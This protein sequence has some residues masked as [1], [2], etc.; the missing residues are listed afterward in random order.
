MLLYEC[1]QYWCDVPAITCLICSIEQLPEN[2]IVNPKSEY[3]NS[4]Q[5][6]MTECYNDKNNEF[7]LPNTS[8]FKFVYFDFEILPA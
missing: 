4:K 1:R 5:I 3:R 2:G 6:P 7:E 8:V